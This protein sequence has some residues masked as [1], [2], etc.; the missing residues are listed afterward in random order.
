MKR[1]LWIL[2]VLVVLS[3][4][5]CSGVALAA[6]GQCGDDVYWSFDPGIG[7]LTISGTGAMWDQ[8]SGI[9]DRPWASYTDSI[10]SV[11]IGDGV[12]YIGANAFRYQSGITSVTIPGSV[13]AIGRLAFYYCTG[14]TS[15]TIQDGVTSIGDQAF[16]YCTGLTSVSIPD[17]VTSI[18]FSAFIACEGLTSVT[19]PGEVTS[20]GHHAFYQCSG[21][22]SATVINASMEFGS[23]AFDQCSSD[24]VMY[25][26]AGSTA[27]AYAE[28]NGITFNLVG[29][30]C[31]DDVYWTIDLDT[32]ALTVS[33]TGP[34]WNWSSSSVDRP[35]TGYRDRITSVVIEDGVTTVGDFAFYAC[36]LTTATFPGSLTSIGECA[37]WNC[38]N[39]TGVS[40]PGSLTTIGRG[41]FDSCYILMSVTIPDSV[42]TVGNTAFGYCYG[43]TSVTIPNSVT[44]LGSFVFD[45]CE[46]LTS[47][48]IPDSVTTIGSNAF[49][50]CKSL[51]SVTIP[52]SVTTIGSA[53]FSRCSSL[54]GVT[55]PNSVTSIGTYAFYN[56][57]SLTSMTIPDGV[58]AIGNAT[59]EGCTNLMNV[60]IPDSVTSIGDDA[61]RS[62]TRLTSV[63]IPNGVTSIGTYAFYNCESLTGV[64]V[65]N[66]SVEF[67]EDIFAN[68]S[69]DL[70]MYGWAGSTAQSY[71]GANGIT[72]RSLPLE[73]ALSGSGTADAPWLIGSKEDWDQIALAVE[74]G[75][76]TAGKHFRLTADIPVTTMIGT[77]ANP[78]GGHVDGDGHTLNV[79][80]TASDSGKA[81][82]AYVS[83]GSFAHLCTAGT[84][85]TSVHDASGL[86][87]YTTGCTIT[88]C[89][90]DIEIVANGGNGHAGFVGGILEGDV[91]I[92]GSLFTGDITG[93][94]TSYCAGFV[95]FGGGVV[96]DSFY[97]G[98]INGA[99]DNNTFLRMVT[100]AG[101]CYYTDSGTIDRVKGQKAR[102]VTADEGIALD[103]GEGTVYSVSGITAYPVGLTYNGVF[104]A[105]AGE[106]VT[107]TLSAPQVDGYAPR[108]TVNAGSLAK[109]DGVWTLTMPDADVVISVTYE[110]VIGQCGDEVF[111]TYDPDTSVLTISGNGPM[112][113]YDNG[114]SGLENV[115]WHCHKEI[116][117]SVVIEEGVTS[118]GSW[119]F[120]FQSG[121]TS[122]TIPDSVTSIGGSAFKQCESLTDVIIPDGVTAIGKFAF[123]SCSSL[124]SVSIPASVVGIGANAF[125]DCD[126]ELVLHGG[127]GS[128]AEAY[129]AYY[130]ILFSAPLITGECGDGVSWVLNPTSG[131]LTISGE[132]AMWDCS[133]SEYPG[134]YG[135][136]DKI[137]A[138]V[139]E[140]GVTNIG[141][142]AFRNMTKVTGVAIPDSVAAIG[143]FAFHKCAGLTELEIPGSVASV[144]KLAFYG[145]AGLSVV[146]LNE[147]L[148]SIDSN[149][150]YGCTSLTG[151]EIP[152]SVTS[153]GYQVFQNCSGL[154]NATILNPSVSIGTKVFTGCSA[155]LVISGYTGSSAQSYAERYSI[156]FKALLP[157]LSFYLPA[158]LTA[159]EDGAFSGIAAEAVYIP[160]TVTDIA[161][162]PFTDSAVQYIYGVS[163]SEA[164]TFADA[165][166]YTFVPFDGGQQPGW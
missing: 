23:N 84:V 121:M 86:V 78:F 109:T 31:G 32:F 20:L 152:D 159:I 154:I 45:H 28:E 44:S 58:T 39:L 55:I 34:M 120:S 98:E 93:A 42:T 73:M 25:G 100:R 65:M 7:V 40:L 90:S 79:D 164:E 22:T 105:G 6:D 145:C 17:G 165:F 116:I 67:G 1:K 2:L 10:T 8:G 64:T 134:W 83:G 35:G 149:A 122:V 103:F 95:G 163:G 113:D 66:R 4:L 21:L 128:T 80:L 139:I 132:G 87:G 9:E 69:S 106:T 137:I 142:Y 136:R 77:E 133:S 118:V 13:T 59:F 143:G 150:F 88:D 108:F 102:W 127:A 75:A 62:C 29:G 16:A 157:E 37:F 54:P 96:D 56:C 19:I 3:G 148:T 71:A 138:V 63:T 160:D 33:G 81:P 46:S 111:W 131:V 43:L 11:A 14:L 38:H 53:A 130:G 18:G 47:V 156:P 104:C 135:Y 41:A 85:T 91:V 153:I 48:T 52:D 124:T 126:P 76:D 60:T 141:A 161:G 151:V 74:G 70:V 89:V 72:F 26:W 36:D 61:F 30:Q 27:Q 51:T 97:D 101:N 166:G 114:D 5:F 24:L 110:P 158:A 140:E 146:T 123:A 125:V 82:F 144:G 50:Q 68:Y 117:T 57:E 94:N 147:G 15:V 155:D 92:A 107:L 112:W 12:T 49:A 119:A 129:A 162:D 115:G 99:H